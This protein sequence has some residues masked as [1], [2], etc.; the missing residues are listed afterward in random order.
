MGLRPMTSAT[1]TVPGDLCLANLFIPF[2]QQGSVTAGAQVMKFQ[3]PHS[4]LREEASWA[5][6]RR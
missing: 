6:K 3:L 5:Q 2:G 4:H 1:H